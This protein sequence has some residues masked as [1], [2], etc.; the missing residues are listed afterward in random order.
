[1]RMHANGRMFEITRDKIDVTSLNRPDTGWGFIDANGHA[2][3]WYVGDQPA[4]L[5]YDPSAS[6]VLPTLHR[7]E[8]G[9]WVDDDG[10]AHAIHENRCIQCQEVIT[11]GM[12]SDD[13]RQFIAG[14]VHYY[15]DGTPVTKE[16]FDAVL[17]EAK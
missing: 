15:I 17:R 11:P 7:V 10:E 16:E 2:H 5:R 6:Y 12:R 14:M 1:M 3:Q 13:T 8:I 4:P 9:R